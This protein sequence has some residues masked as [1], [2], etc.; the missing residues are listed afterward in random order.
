MSWTWEYDPGEE[1]VA[2]GAPPAFVAEVEKRAD[3]LV[4]AAE[5]LYLDGTTYQEVSPGSSDQFVPGGMFR[6]LV[7]PR[8]ER[9]YVVQITPW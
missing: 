9:L 2:G 1:N 3:E 8:H 6:Y 5:A 4:R 7:V